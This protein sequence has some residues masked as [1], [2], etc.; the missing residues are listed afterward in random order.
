MRAQDRLYFFSCIRTRHAIKGDLFFNIF[1]DEIDVL[2]LDDGESVGGQ[3][4]HESEVS[5][6][7]ESE[8]DPNDESDDGDD[9]EVDVSPG[10]VRVTASR[11]GA[12]VMD[13][14]DSEDDNNSEGEDEKDSSK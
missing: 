11:F 5:D 3:S 14:N 6:D 13:D 1:G 4:D 7:E 10:T 9:E 12:L 2:E 8:V